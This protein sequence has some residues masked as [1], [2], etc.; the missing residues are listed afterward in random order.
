MRAAARMNDCG[1]W[2]RAKQDGS[3]LAEANAGFVEVVRGHLDVDFVADGD[4]DKVFAHLAGDV[5][6][7]FMA[8]GQ[9]HPEHGTGQHLRHGSGEF[10]VFFFWHATGDL[11][12]NAV[13]RTRLVCAT[14]HRRRKLP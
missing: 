11:V 10:D 5:G 13:V 7:D 1:K 3:A 2:L 9:G 12:P 14:L 8:V 4:A 6:E